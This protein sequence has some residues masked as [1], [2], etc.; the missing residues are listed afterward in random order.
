MAE[1]L[2]NRHFA[3]LYL[4]LCKLISRSGL[5]LKFSI[6]KFKEAKFLLELTD[7]VVKKFWI[8]KIKETEFFTRTDLGFKIPN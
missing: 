3:S 8:Q 1:F 7:F 5:L 2:T 4:L 6:Q